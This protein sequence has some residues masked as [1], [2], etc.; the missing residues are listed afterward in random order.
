MKQKT[1]RKVLI[2]MEVFM[3]MLQNVLLL[4]LFA[5]AVSTV[6]ADDAQ[7]SVVTDDKKNNEQRTQAPVVT[8]PTATTSTPATTAPAVTTETS[9]T[10]TSSADTTKT[11]PTATTTTAS[12]TTETTT[13]AA[14]SQEIDQAELDKFL[15]M[16]EAE[17]A[18]ETADQKAQ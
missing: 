13:T 17:T 14:D 5:G 3:N 6:R 7:T 1:S 12:T 8:T 10:T 9:A 4:A 11:A 2:I 16:L 15:K 18:K